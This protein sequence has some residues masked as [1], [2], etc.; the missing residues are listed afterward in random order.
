MKSKRMFFQDNQSTM[1]LEKNSHSSCSKKSRHIDIHFFFMKDRVLM[2]GININIVQWNRCWPISSQNHYKGALFKH[3]KSIIMGLYHISILWHVKL[4]PNEECVE[5]IKN[6]W[7]HKTYESLNGTQVKISKSRPV[8][9]FGH[10]ASTNKQMFSSKV[11]GNY[12]MASK[13]K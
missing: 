13:S 3:L 10:N 9:T 4:L 6:R 1:R 2:E 12:R 5:N 11:Q 7:I 8:V